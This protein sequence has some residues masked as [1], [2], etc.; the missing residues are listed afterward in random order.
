[1]VTLAFSEPEESLWCFL[2]QLLGYSFCGIYGNE[3]EEFALIAKGKHHF[4]LAG[5]TFFTSL[6]LHILMW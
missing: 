5:G 6:L 2:S 3:L 4:F 1:M